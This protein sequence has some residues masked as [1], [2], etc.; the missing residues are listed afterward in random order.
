MDRFTSG[1]AHETNILDAAKCHG[2]ILSKVQGHH[3]I[4][5]TCFSNNF[6]KPPEFGDVPW[7]A[8][9]IKHH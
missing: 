9:Y 4:K 3:P 6:K 2:G 1:G 5:A 8:V 7:F